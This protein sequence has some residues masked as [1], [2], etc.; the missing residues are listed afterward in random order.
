[1]K[2]AET[3]RNDKGHMRGK[4]K[5]DLLLVPRRIEVDQGY[6]KLQYF[7]VQLLQILQNF[8]FS[9]VDMEIHQIGQQ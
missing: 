4:G 5:K 9:L 2:S 3:R 8:S 1:M 6:E 7:V